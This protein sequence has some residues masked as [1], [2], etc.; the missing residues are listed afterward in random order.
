MAKKKF[1]AVKKGYE[2]GV[3]LTWEDCKKQIH[4]Y[5]SAEYKGFL[6]LKEAENFMIKSKEEYKEVLEE[7]TVKAYV[8]GSYDHSTL[9]YAG[10]AV[11]ILEDKEILISEAGDNIVLAKMRNV[12][13][14]LLGAIRV[15]E[16]FA[17]NREKLELEKLMIYY[18]YEGIE[19]W[20]T[21]QWKAKKEGTQLYVSKYKEFRQQFF[22]QFVK[23]LAHS[24]DYYNDKADELAKKALGIS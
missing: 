23:V 18:D 6:T 1:Y 4:G 2:P 20:A 22:I 15:M 16:W 21:G 14:E 19:K 10:G 12:A 24:G 7:K 8:D 17:D 13:G 9:R 3:Y 11:I 5:S